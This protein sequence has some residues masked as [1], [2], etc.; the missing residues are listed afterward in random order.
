MN[1]IDT[2]AH[3]FPK[4][5]FSASDIPRGASKISTYTVSQHLA[6]LAA[7]GEVGLYLS[8]PVGFA[9]DPRL[10]LAN[11]R[12]AEA[13][14]VRTG[15]EKTRILALLAMDPSFLREGLFHHTGI[16]GA[17]FTVEAQTPD[18]LRKTGFPEG[19]W[20]ECFR[21]FADTH[22]QLHVRVTN[23]DTLRFLLDVLPPD[24]IVALDHLG[25]ASGE[26][27]PAD[28]GFQSVLKAAADRGRVYFKGPGFRTSLDPMKVA[29]VVESILR[30]CGPE[31]VWL[32]AT[33]APFLWSDADS[34]Q[35][36]QDL[37]PSTSRALDYVSTLAHRVGR[38]P[39]DPDSPS[40]E[41][42]LSGNILR[43]F[44]RFG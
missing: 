40:A 35:P 7:A 18:E 15:S 5:W 34:G 30:S 6:S 28:P 43:V 31:S 17:R 36:L 10:M 24:L 4:G 37:I 16:A 29:P 11:L 9:P 44:D 13:W 41:D 33:D 42:L 26:A 19:E 39:G 21:F 20:A 8:V 25:L 38:G 1:I 22:R 2:H 27:A 3:A 14:K 12:E 23:N 32:G